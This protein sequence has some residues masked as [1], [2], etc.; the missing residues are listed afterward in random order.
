[1]DKA[2]VNAELRKLFGDTVTRQQ[3]FDYRAKTGVYPVWIRRDESLRVG[4][5]LYRIPGADVTETRPV[6]PTP[7]DEGLYDDA[8]APAKKAPPAPVAA[9]EKSE[10]RDVGDRLVVATGTLHFHRCTS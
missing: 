5:G 7:F 9:P 4:R 1:M 6:L 2:K 8:P 3:L 10:P